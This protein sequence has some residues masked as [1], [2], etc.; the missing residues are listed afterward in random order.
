MLCVLRNLLEIC[1]YFSIKLCFQQLLSVK[2]HNS[3]FSRD[4]HGASF[5]IPG[6]NPTD[7]SPGITPTG[8]LWCVAQFPL[9]TSPLGPEP[10]NLKI[11]GPPQTTYSW[12]G[13]SPF[14]VEH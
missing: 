6:T 9:L 12:F 2:M 11:S 8:R 13:N 10:K 1:P 14:S 3:H 4:L 7:G 5:D